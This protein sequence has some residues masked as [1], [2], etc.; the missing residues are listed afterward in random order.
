MASLYSYGSS[1]IGSGEIAAEPKMIGVIGKGLL[2]IELHVEFKILVVLTLLKEK[3]NFSIIRLL[4]ISIPSQRYAGTIG[5]L[6]GKIWYIEEFSS[7][8]YPVY[9]CLFDSK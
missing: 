3:I 9:L 7:I 2:L 6:P 1:E 4:S 5:K 8:L